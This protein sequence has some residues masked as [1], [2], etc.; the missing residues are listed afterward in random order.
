MFDLYTESERLE[1]ERTL[2]TLLNTKPTCILHEISLSAQINATKH[3]IA[4][5]K[6]ELRM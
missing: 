4:F 2:V 3:R 5:A 1:L 6:G